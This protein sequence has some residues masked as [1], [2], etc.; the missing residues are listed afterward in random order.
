MSAQDSEIAEIIRSSHLADLLYQLVHHA[1]TGQPFDVTFFDREPLLDATLDDIFASKF[2]ATVFG[3]ASALQRLCERVKFSDDTV[4]PIAAIW[5]LNPMPPGGIDNEALSRADLAR[6]EE[7]AGPNGETIRE[8]IADTYH[9][10][11]TAELDWHTR[12][13]IAS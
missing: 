8:M 9:C 7:A 2:L 3:P 5:I 13:W 11:S 1:K 12:R 6:A 4:V 10:E